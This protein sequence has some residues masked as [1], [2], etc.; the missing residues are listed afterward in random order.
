M[1]TGPDAV[2]AR[3]GTLID[4]RGASRF[5]AFVLACRL[6]TLATVGAAL[7]TIACS[8]AAD[9]PAAD[10]GAS[11]QVVATIPL[12]GEFAEHVAGPDAD[13]TTLVPL[14]VDEHAF[15]PST[16]VAR[17]VAG[18]DLAL[19][20][21]YRLEEGLLSIVVENV[22]GGVPV[23]AVSRGL[24]PHAPG[25]EHEGEHEDEHDEEAVPTSAGAV[26]EEVF[27][28]GDPHFWL[29]ARNA[30]RYVENIRDALVAAD[31]EH[32]DG[33]RERAAAL[34]GELEALDAELRELLAVIPP[35][36]RKV[37]VFHDAYAY[38]ADAYDFEV[39]ASVAPA[40][41]N[42]AAS[43]ASIAEIVATVRA[44]GVQAIY[45]E[46][47]YSGQALDLIAEESGATVGVLYSIPTDE[48]P[49]YAEMMRANAQVL[50]EGLAR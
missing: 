22:R 1:D 4:N 8:G 14:G 27:A 19:V 13:V 15:Q 41:P 32:A 20:N 37:V 31:A 42:Q 7:L 39:I 6:A 25:S 5:A 36:R 23:V 18:A 30:I 11:L 10:G 44:E 43:A 46:P 33:Y 28:E 48:V 12:I 17:T 3:S 16:T 35:E 9:G 2:R 50:V 40:N 29:D 34:I 26:A 45:R 24:R 47:Q 49:T 21:G 38:F